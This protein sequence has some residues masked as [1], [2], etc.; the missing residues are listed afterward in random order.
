[1]LNER[2]G[3]SPQAPSPSLSRTL[4][5][6]EQARAALL[7]R[8]ALSFQRSLQRCMVQEMSLWER[9]IMPIE[10]EI[11]IF[12]NDD[13]PEEWRVEYFDEDGL[14][15]ARRVGINRRAEFASPPGAQ[16]R[17]SRCFAS[18]FLA[19]RTAAEGRLCRPFSRGGLEQ[20]AHALPDFRAEGV[21]RSNAL[22]M[23][24]NWL[25]W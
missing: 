1:M 7:I 24:C 15:R 19:Q 8:A 25:S 5:P 4:F 17:Q 20:E 22:V 10:S 2:Q 14:S 23:K 18:V 13:E 6:D 3:N 16:E 11:M 12:Q 21:G 9:P